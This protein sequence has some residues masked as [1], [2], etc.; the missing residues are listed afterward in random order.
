MADR[1]RRPATG[2]GGVLVAAALLAACAVDQGVTTQRADLVVEQAD[3]TSPAITDPAITDPDATDPDATDP[4]TT[5]PVTTDPAVT[6]PPT[7]DPP[8][9]DPATSGPVTS[10]PPGSL[11]DLGTDKPARD[12][13]E[14]IRAAL[15]DIER[16][17][18]EQYPI[19]YGAPFEPLRGGL[20]AGYPERE[21]PIPG[22]GPD[23][24]TTYDEIATFAAFYCPDGDFMAYDDGQDGVLYSLTSE[25][26]QAIFGVVLAHEYGH[27][28]QQRAGVLDA[29]PATILTEQQADCFSGAWVA[30]AANGEAPGVELTDQDIRSGLIAI[31]TVRDPIGID[32]FSPGGHGS[33][34][35]R[36]GAFQVGFTEGSGRCVGLIDD[37]LPLMPNVFT[38]GSAD[39]DGNA[40]F[41]YAN[42]QIVFFT[43]G[44]LNAFWAAALAG[45]SDEPFTPLAVVPFDDP[46]TVEC[47]D[48]VGDEQ[49]GALF[50]PSTRQVFLDDPL[51]RSRY[52]DFGDFAVAYMLAAAWSEA[53]QVAIGSPLR[54]ED[55]ALVSDCFSGAWAATL[56]PGEDGASAAATSVIIEPGDLDEA[57]QTALAVGDDSSSED[58]LGSPF[59]KIAS[60]R[61]GVLGGVDAC[62]DLV[63]D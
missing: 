40:D 28:I 25:F 21:E 24:E 18:A 3:T 58:V 51:A 23:E 29:D 61:A 47:G 9:T 45:R 35:D 22:C 20:Y 37:P 63:P 54:D 5:E 1:R 4:V 62:R 6:E 50:C 16:W 59:E 60:F 44:D 31:I 48:V 55:R 49:I 42:G 19:L 13:D 7:T 11:L 39:A 57:I 30:R 12:Y 33:A 17:W 14:F 41:G 15:R 27:A 32:Q 10:T 36:V 53:A 46:A 26:G 8:T 38:P 56:V 43:V 2:L 52:G 34:F